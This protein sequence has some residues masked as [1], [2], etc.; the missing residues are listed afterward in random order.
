MFSVSPLST[1]TVTPLDTLMSMLSVTPSSVEFPVAVRDEPLALVTVPFLIL[2]LVARFHEPVE[3]LS[4]RVELL[5]SSVPVRFTV[6]PLRVQVVP[7]F[8]VKLPPRFKVPLLTL[9][10]PVLLQV[11]PVVKVVPLTFIVPELLQVPALGER[12][13]APV[14]D[15][16]VPELVIGEMM[17]IVV[18]AV[19]ARMVP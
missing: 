10:V 8:S 4:V 13:M 11:P 9:M 7:L 14:V 12:L 5:L 17:F 2:P 18:E 16:M 15:S 3:E 6:P 1:V 19:S